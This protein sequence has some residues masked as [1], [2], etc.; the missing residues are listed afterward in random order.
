MA[1]TI[2]VPTMA[3]MY[4]AGENPE[5]LFWVGCAGSFDDRAKKITK[6]FVKI[7]NKAN[8]SFAVLG[9]EES[10]TGDPAKRAGNEFLF[11]M[12]AVTNIEVLN[13][14]EIKKIVTT[15][16]HCFNT[17]KN[18]YPGLGGTYEVVHHTQFL[19]ELLKEGRITVEGGTFKGKRI[20]FHDPCYLG[21]ANGVYEA[22][23]ELIRKLDAELIEM[24]NCKQRGLCC[25]AGGARM[26]KE[27][28]KGDKDVN[29]ERTEQALETTPDIIAAGCPFC[30]TMMTDGVKNKEREDS[31]KVLDIAELIATAEDL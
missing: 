6:A 15:C 21:R 24:K 18:E 29:I 16:P 3:E 7:L 17:I 9:T 28:E 4:A 27:P 10:C 31:I 20:T 12:Q 11:Q 30:N 13:A 26:F 22:P 8:I 2:K 19:K 1:D 14:Y 25:G 5:V 23:R